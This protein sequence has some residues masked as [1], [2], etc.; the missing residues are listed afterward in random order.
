MQFQNF[1]LFSKLP[2]NL[3]FATSFNIHK[4]IIIG[5]V[6]QWSDSCEI[7]VLSALMAALSQGSNFLY[8]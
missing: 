7:Y 8:L 2:E 4:Q 5:S 6:T 1:M 3:L